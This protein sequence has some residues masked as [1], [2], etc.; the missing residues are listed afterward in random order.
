M[1][2]IS[3]KTL[4]FK[5]ASLRKKEDENPKD[6][7]KKIVELLSRVK[8]L[9]SAE[10]AKFLLTNA[11]YTKLDAD[12]LSD[13][14]KHKGKVPAIRIFYTAA[15]NK[16]NMEEALL[17]LKDFKDETPVPKQ[18]KPTKKTPDKKQ[19]EPKVSIPELSTI[20]KVA[21]MNIHNGD[22]KVVPVRTFSR[23]C[24]LKLVSKSKNSVKMT[25]LG[26]TVVNEL[27]QSGVQ[28]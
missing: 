19:S 22:A 9:Y 14:E 25:Q 21:M 23:L 11:V 12:Y 28:A 24:D 4:G 5:R 3:M 2:Q 18:P 16:K 6:T 10:E 13:P 27:I 15:R 26:Q 1:K 8:D 17:K 7:H 20:Q